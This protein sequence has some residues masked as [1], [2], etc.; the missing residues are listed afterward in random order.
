MKSTPVQMLRRN[1]SKKPAPLFPGRKIVWRGAFLVLLS[2]YTVVAVYVLERSWGAVASPHA[3]DIHHQTQHPQLHRTA[4]VVP[5]L[6]PLH[7]KEGDAVQPVRTNGHGISDVA[8]D[9]DRDRVWEILRA[10]GV[11]EDTLTR[12]AAQLP[13]WS[14]IVEQ[15][16]AHPVLVGLESCAAYRASVPEEKR[17][18]GAAGMFNTGTNLVTQLLKHNCYIPARLRLY[19]SSATKEQLGMRWQVR[20][21]IF[22]SSTRMICECRIGAVASRLPL[23]TKDAQT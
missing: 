6:H 1:H 4:A 10:A 23:P 18:L 16:G 14:A 11:A 5:P 17:M 12:R 15:Y 9:N 19:G 7:V 22:V 21:F 13:A 8:G 2:G 3:D 20:E